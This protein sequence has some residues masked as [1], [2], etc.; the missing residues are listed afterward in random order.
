MGRPAHAPAGDPRNRVGVPGRAR[1]VVVLAALA[2][3]AIAVAA[4][5]LPPAAPHADVRSPALEAAVVVRVN[6][7]RRSH[8]LVPLR[9]SAALAAAADAHSREQAAGGYF[10]HASTDGSPFWRRIERFYPAKPFAYWSTGENLLWSSRTLDAAAAVRLWLASPEHRR[11]LLAPRW[12]ELGLS[13][14][15]AG[16][17]PGAFG[18]RDVVILTADF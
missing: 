18:G 17:A 8:G 14:L 11:N 2:A 10:A 15:E 4:P 9:L 6:A 12:R 5:S 16:A 13:A 7:L 3:S 1:A